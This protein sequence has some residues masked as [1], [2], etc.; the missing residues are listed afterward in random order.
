MRPPA[1]RPAALPAR[2][3]LVL[4][5]SLSSCF[6]QG[7]DGTA[8]ARPAPDA[9]ALAR[10]GSCSRTSLFQ[11]LLGRENLEALFLCTGWSA[12]FP[13]LF[14]ALGSIDPDDWD[15]L[16]SPLNRRVL[17]DGER[18]GRLIAVLGG[19]GAADGFAS[20]TRSMAL[21]HG[22]DVHGRLH[23]LLVEREGAVRRL[24]SSLEPDGA[25][26]AR[27]ARLLRGLAG[28]L[29]SMGD[30]FAE[31]LAGLVGSP[32]F[33]DAR[34]DLVE[35][36]LALPGDPGA[37]PSLEF[38][39]RLMEGGG[40]GLPGAMAD[41]GLRGAAVRV[42]GELAAAEGR[43]SVRRAAARVWGLSED[44]TAPC[45]GPDGEGALFLDV[46]GYLDGYVR[47]LADGDRRAF[48]LALAE[49]AVLD[50]RLP[51]VCPGA[52]GWASDVSLL[53]RGV[54]EPFDGPGAF[55]LGA[56]AA[57][58]LPEP[59]VG[60]LLDAL[61][62]IPAGP[63]LRLVRTAL[64]E[65]PGFLDVLL[66]MA[67]SLPPG[68]WDDAAQLH[69]E[70]ARGGSAPLFGAL[71]EVLAAFPREERLALVRFLDGHFELGS[72]L[73]PLLGFLADALEAF[74]DDLVPA[75]REV[76][77]SEDALVGS[78]RGV[79]LHLRGEEVLGDLRRFFSRDHMIRIL[80]FLSGGPWPPAA[81]GAAAAVSPPAASPHAAPGPGTPPSP[82][83][84]S[85]AFDLA[86]AALIDR[87]AALLG[88]SPSLF[89]WLVRPAL[90]GLKVLDGLLR[91]EGGTWEGLLDGAGRA[92]GGAGGGALKAALR[93]ADGLLDARGGRELGAALLRLPARDA[94]LRAYA[95][96]LAGSLPLL[97][98]DWR[99]FSP[100]AA[101]VAAP[102]AAPAA[103]PAPCRDRANL[104]V[105]GDPCPGPG[106]LAAALEEA[107]GLLARRTAAVRPTALA[108]YLSL[109][110]PGRGA[111]LPGA[112]GRGE[113]HRLPLREAVRML[114]SLSDGRG[115]SGRRT[116]AF[117]G[118][119]RVERRPSATVLESLEGLARES[120]FHG[121][122]LV[123]RYLNALAGARD[124]DA[125]VARNGRVFRACAFL[126]LCGGWMDGD[127]RRM[128]GNALAFLPG[129][130]AAGGGG[131]GGGGGGLGHGDGV[132]AFLAPL[133]ASSAGP[134]ARAGLLRPLALSEDDLARHNGGLLVLAA[135][136]ALFSNAA[137]VL[138]DL[139]GG[140][141]AADRMLL[142]SPGLRLVSGRFLAD[143]RD[144][145]AFT[146]RL[147]SAL[148]ASA[149]VRDARGRSLLSALAHGVAGMRPADRR[150]LAGALADGLVALHLL[151][152]DGDGGDGNV[153]DSAR[154]FENGALLLDRLVRAWP[155]LADAA[156]AAG[157][158]D[159]GGALLASLAARSLRFLRGGLADPA[160]RALY[161]RLAGGLPR[162]LS[163]ALLAGRADGGVLGLLARDG[164]AATALA[165]LAAALADLAGSAGSGR[166]GPAAA[167]GLMVLLPRLLGDGRLR[168]GEALSYLDLASRPGSPLPDPLLAP[169]S[170]L[171]D[172]D[173]NARRL[174]EEAGPL[175]RFLSR[176]LGFFG[177]A[178]P[179]P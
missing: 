4:S 41:P 106:A 31:G 26:L 140:G 18:L 88:P 65:D 80:N 173:G 121:G 104:G 51:D 33:E 46:E 123:A 6:R 39:A 179:V 118:R 110:S 16:A 86:G 24:L 132:R 75:A 57:G 35:A 77:A 113:T 148:E 105:G 11:D 61:G 54:L 126:N 134:A 116:V 161:R 17:D 56:L 103:P 67:G 138:R 145:G 112:G 141:P 164:G 47:A 59:G 127:D 146:G 136:H 124:Y 9:E 175:G 53:R 76:L 119:D 131:D 143:V 97:V 96:D 172:F 68:F 98:R 70:L 117:T 71:G 3:A 176:A 101:P 52:R 1:A 22:G 84:G 15:L 167:P 147:G 55:R 102:A 8:P 108:L 169:A 162:A 50:A 5:L 74:G 20:L 30:A 29:G 64:A 83:P 32:G 107:A 60:P 66:G 58:A 14:A 157:A 23:R 177:L 170:L 10:A 48:S 90:V 137:R 178:A 73:A 85:A 62:R 44:G 125:A 42:L 139:A 168:A 163:R 130:M 114:L 120:A 43:P 49:D 37:G 2:A 94:S 135:R 153:V 100:A 78:L 151:G 154:P 7:P 38:A 87:A 129:A 128:A 82:A 91:G 115:P 95:R 19:L 152:G 150:V 92:A 28:A 144:M 111:E 165:D 160:S 12:R 79:S 81:P 45:D 142:E 34:L 69:R 159:D 21:V 174:A 133:V 27:T 72:G 25:S 149:S 63:L 40:G 36:L 158:L 171:E 13:R 155:A 109:L 166:G 156:D 99:A 93:L 122:R 89:S